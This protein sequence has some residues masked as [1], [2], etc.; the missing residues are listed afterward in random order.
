MAGRSTEEAKRMLFEGI[1]MVA[2]QSG[3]VV[4]EGHRVRD[5]RLS[6]GRVRC[7]AARN[8]LLGWGA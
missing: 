8:L 2:R 7:V 5:G 4:A 6:V 1:E 3:G